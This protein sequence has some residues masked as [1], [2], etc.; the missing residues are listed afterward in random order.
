[1]IYFIQDTG[2]QTIKIG[3]SNTPTK[4]LE[5]LQTAN[6]NPLVMLGTIPGSREEEDLLHQQFVSYRLQGEWFQGTP[7][8]V[9]AIKR[10][11]LR[12]GK[13]STVWDECVRR[14]RCRY[15]L[16]GVEVALL[17]ADGLCKVVSS[18][19]GRDGQL[20]LRLHPFN[21]PGEISEF[22]EVPA[23]K[24]VLMSDWPVVCCP[25]S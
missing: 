4:R 3:L 21:C 22:I 2:N 11:L 18:C 10:L 23:E 14:N 1:V 13:P 12:S 24:C 8:V 15:G 16:R 20:L 6:A 9:A 7:E 19:W 17:G 5:A 25:P